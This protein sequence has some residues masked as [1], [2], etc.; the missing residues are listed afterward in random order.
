M[1]YMDREKINY[2]ITYNIPHNI[3]PSLL[4]KNYY[5]P[6]VCTLAMVSITFLQDIYGFYDIYNSLWPLP[7]FPEFADER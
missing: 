3:S 2:N 7:G 5:I 1:Y 6:M 4:Q